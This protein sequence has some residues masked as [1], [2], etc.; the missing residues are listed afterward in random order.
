MKKV[1]ELLHGQNT[2]GEEMALDHFNGTLSMLFE[3]LLYAAPLQMSHWRAAALL[4]TSCSNV[5][6]T[7]T[8]SQILE[9]MKQE[10]DMVVGLESKACSSSLLQR[11]ACYSRWQVNREHWNVPESLKEFLVSWFPSVQGSSTVEDI[12]FGDSRCLA[13]FYQDRCGFSA[14]PGLRD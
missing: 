10:W 5:D 1:L 14:E 4:A 11:H 13:T 8:H 12:F 2:S 6:V 7:A 9:S 3:L